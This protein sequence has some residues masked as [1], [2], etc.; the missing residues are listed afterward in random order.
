[1]TRKGAAILLLCLSTLVACES[2]PDRQGAAPGSADVQD[3]NRAR[4]A[5]IA[6]VAPT[7]CRRQSDHSG[8][9]P[10]GTLSK[11]DGGDGGLARN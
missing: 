8:N 9:F 2:W 6:D 3:T 5:C 10:F 7:D 1:M 11:G 4:T